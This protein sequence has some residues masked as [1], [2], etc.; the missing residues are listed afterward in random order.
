V[1]PIRV[2]LVDMPRLLRDLVSEAIDAAPGMEVVGAITD[3]GD[4]AAV[5]ADTDA[6]VVVFTSADEELPVAFRR[7]LDAHARLRLLALDPDGRDMRAFAL[8]LRERRLGPGSPEA[9]VAA[10]RAPSKRRRDR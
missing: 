8:A 4:L 9:V 10:I 6:D 2:L 5:V 1:A 7:A 3:A